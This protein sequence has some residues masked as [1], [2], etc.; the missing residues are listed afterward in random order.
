MAD[1]SLREDQLLVLAPSGRDAVLATQLLEQGGMSAAI[2]GSA[3]ELVAAIAEGAGGA[4]VAQE[5]LSLPVIAALAGALRNQPPWS[6]FPLIIFMPRTA[7]AFENRRAL[8]AFAELG[9]VT[10]LE[11]PI[12]PLTRGAPGAHPSVCGAHR[13]G[14]AGARCQAARSIPGPAR[15]RTAQSAG[16]V[17]KRVQAAG[18]R[19]GQR[20]ANGEPARHH[21]SAD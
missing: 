11:R 18:A 17:A 2:C 21:R 6:D 3:D 1:R 10:A 19:C 14:T 4:L 8:E 9:N 5:A 15:S 13:T 7:S 12:H 16:G 20:S